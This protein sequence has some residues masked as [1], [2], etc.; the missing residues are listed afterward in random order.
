MAAGPFTVPCFDLP[1]LVCINNE[2]KSFNAVTPKFGIVYHWTDEI[3]TY[4][5]VSRGFKSG[6]FGA[7]DLLPAFN[8]EKIWAYEA[9]IKMLDAE[10][11]W[12]LNLSGFHYDYKDLQI[13][14]VIDGFTSTSNAASSTVDGFELE[15]KILL[16]EGLTVTDAFAYLDAQYKE[17]NIS[18]PAFPALGIQDLSGNQLQHAPNFTNNLLLRYDTPVLGDKYSVCFL[19]GIGGTGRITLNLIRQQQSKAQCQ[20]LMLQFVWPLTKVRAGM[21]KAGEEPDR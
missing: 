12:S 18:D 13:N 2:S 11:R 17:F 1:N 5:T 7:S 9:G 20:L 3:M 8:P 19:S 16:F 21:S 6:G 14:Q 4:A 10:G 15:G